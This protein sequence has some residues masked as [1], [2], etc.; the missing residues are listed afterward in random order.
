MRHTLGAAAF[1]LAMLASIALFQKFCTGCWALGNGALFVSLDGPATGTF[2]RI[3]LLPVSDRKDWIDENVLESPPEYLLNMAKHFEP[4]EF[5]RLPMRVEIMVESTLDGWG[6]ELNRYQDGQILVFALT[7]S[8][9]WVS[10][11]RPIPDLRHSRTMTIHLPPP[12]QPLPT[13]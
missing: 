7:K 10:T 4:D 8:G 2:E 12:D 9:Q 3:A 11:I 5:E 1:F 6:C 13:P